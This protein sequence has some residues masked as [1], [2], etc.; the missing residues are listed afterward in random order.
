MVQNHYQKS[1]RHTLPW[2]QTTDAY[3]IA[4]SEIMLQQT[5]VDRVVPKYSAF[6][7][8]FPT[9][10]KLAKASWVDVLKIWTG[11]GYNRRAKFL[12]QM[13]QIVVTKYNG[14]LPRDFGEL[15]KL[16]GIG[17]YTAGAIAAF[18]FNQAFPIIETNIRTVYIHHF[19]K[20]T[21][22]VSDGDVY[23]SIVKTLDIQNPRQWYWALMDYGSFLK[24]TGNKVH[25]TSKH[26]TKQ[27]TFKGSRRQMRGA[28]MRAL[29]ISPMTVKSL[30]TKTK[31]KDSEVRSVLI[32]LVKE[33]FII[34][35]GQ[36]YLIV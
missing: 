27:T 34:Q 6:L 14:K 8:R 1:G 5:Q 23:K 10:Q 35:K 30:V 17:P 25:R 4:V 13:A 19:F 16:P 18:A 3:A 7:K 36:K 2:R 31:G 20:H 9:I 11:L 33:N 28:L 26:Y 15:K 12:H 21:E 24:Q 22:N 29:L 32:D